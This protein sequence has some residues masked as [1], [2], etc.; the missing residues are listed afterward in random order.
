MAPATIILIILVAL[1]MLGAGGCVLCV[2]VSAASDNHR[3]GALDSP[4]WNSPLRT[5]AARS[6]FQLRAAWT[7]VARGEPHRPPQP[8]A[9]N[10]ARPRWGQKRSRTSARIAH[11]SGWSQK[12][13]RPLAHTTPLS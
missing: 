1:I 12:W 11:A 9:Q 13:I 8:A 2:C 3:R 10:E 6:P 7:S 5:S 4:A